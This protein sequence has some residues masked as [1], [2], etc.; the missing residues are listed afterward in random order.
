MKYYSKEDISE[1][2]S[3]FRAHFI[4]SV[5]GYKS[6]NLIGTKSEEGTSNLAVFSSVTHLGSNPPL[7]GFV[8]RPTTVVRNTY[9]NL[10]KSGV[11]TVNHVNAD[12]IKQAHQT[13]AKYDSN[14]SEF[15]ETRLTEEYLNDFKAPFVKESSIKLGCV[16]QNEYFLEENQCIFVIA[17]IEHIYLD[18]SIQSEDGWLNL[19]EAG[20]V[21]ASGLDAYAIPKILDRFSY[22]KPRKKAHSIK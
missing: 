12:I 19:E 6:S 16:Y 5:T 13:S 9:D 4:N 15:S 3:R 2:T 7:L 14:V 18:E 17:N 10:K 8:L 1:L 22:A 11:F 20:T 21:T